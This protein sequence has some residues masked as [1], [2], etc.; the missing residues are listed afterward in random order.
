VSSI[1]SINNRTDKSAQNT[2]HN[3][4]PCPL[5]ICA[6]GSILSTLRPSLHALQHS[7]CGLCGEQSRSKEIYRGMT[8]RVRGISSQ[9]RERESGENVYR[10]VYPSSYCCNHLDIFVSEIVHFIIK[11]HRGDA[12]RADTDTQTQTHRHRHA[13]A[14]DYR[15]H[16]AR[17]GA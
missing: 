4:S 2:E 13:F 12:L 5:C 11:N 17:S 16:K 10:C 9:R 8:V 14:Y 1:N 15:S 6:C 7:L 3:C